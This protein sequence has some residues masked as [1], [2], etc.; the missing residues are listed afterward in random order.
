MPTNRTRYAILGALTVAPMSGYGLRQFFD[1]SVSFFWRESYGQIYP[2]LKQLRRERL[3]TTRRGTRGEHS[4]GRPQYVITSRGREALRAWLS[5]AVEL[6]PPRQELLLK[7]G[8]LVIAQNEE[9]GAL[10][11]R[12]VGDDTDVF[13]RVPGGEAMNQQNWDYAIES[14][15]QAATLVPDN[16]AYRQALRGCER[17]KYKDN[18][19]S[20]P[21][22]PAII[23]K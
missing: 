21:P 22:L 13:V 6:Q 1:Q 3:I 4:S 9:M 8:N 18:K 11:I 5:E 14:F 20:L 23:I 7:L 17:K 16:V 10:Y 12:V 15:L 19:T 2:I